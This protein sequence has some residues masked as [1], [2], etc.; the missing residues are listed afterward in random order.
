MDIISL[1]RANLRRAIDAKN[2]SEGFT[3]DAAF[4]ERYDLNPS[5][6]SQLV[7]GHGSF[8]ER[9]ARNLE[10]KV[11]WEDG[12]LDRV[13]E[14]TPQS[15]AELKFSNVQ[16]STSPLHKIPVLDFVQAGLFHECGYDGINPKG[17]TYTTY[18]NAKPEC[19]FS[20]EVSGLSMAPE[21]NPGDKLVVDASKPP[22]PGCYVIAQNGSHEATFKKYRAIG[23]DE[24]GRETFELI[25]LNPDF[26]TMNSV[27]QEI[28]IIGVVVEHLR[29]FN[30]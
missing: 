9:A 29:S 16:P 8:G 1:R 10:K 2:K 7:K 6:I 28:R 5:H 27:Q 23:Y 26:P 3:S 20:L 25:P 11:G 4:C 12:F 15:T 30:K 13:D 19:V 18:Q 24:H 22:Y 14:A 21:F 17:D